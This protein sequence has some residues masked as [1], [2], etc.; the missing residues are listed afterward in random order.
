[1]DAWTVKCKTA[2]SR[3]DDTLALIIDRDRARKLQLDTTTK[4]SQMGT[5]IQELKRARQVLERE[6]SQLE[7]QVDQTY[8]FR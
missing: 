2:L 5:Q 6:L 4:D 1:M 8:S 7:Q 3:A